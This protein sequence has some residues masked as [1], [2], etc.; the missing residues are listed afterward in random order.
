MEYDKDLTVGHRDYWRAILA[1]V[2][3]DE[4]KLDTQP[5]VC[6]TIAEVAEVSQ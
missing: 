1:E 3:A 2:R 4:K 5:E 6:A